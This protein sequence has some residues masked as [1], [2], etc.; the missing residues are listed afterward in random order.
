MWR[1]NGESGGDLMR[2][3]LKSGEHRQCL[4]RVA[5]FAENVA[6]ESNDR[7]RSEDAGIGMASS[8]LPGLGR[9]HPLGKGTGRFRRIRGF[10]YGGRENLMFQAKP[11]EVFFSPG[12]GGGKDERAGGSKHRGSDQRKRGEL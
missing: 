3:P 9:R 11:R 8:N 12:G 6:I 7:V 10:V 1:H 4:L 5:G 2:S